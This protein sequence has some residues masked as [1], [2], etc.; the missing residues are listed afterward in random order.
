[1]DVRGNERPWVDVG[2]KGKLWVDVRARGWMQEA[3]GGRGWLYEAMVGEGCVFCNRLCD[4][5]VKNNRGLHFKRY[6]SNGSNA[7]F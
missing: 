1:M 2:G 3:T 4:L 6:T 5:S 7:K